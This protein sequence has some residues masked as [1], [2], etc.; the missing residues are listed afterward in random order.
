MARSFLGNWGYL[1]MGEFCLLSQL[2]TEILV[3]VPV[4]KIIIICYWDIFI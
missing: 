3:G 2:D 1:K 4:H